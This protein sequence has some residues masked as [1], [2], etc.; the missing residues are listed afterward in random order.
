MSALEW[1]KETI[2]EEAREEGLQEGREEGRVQGLE[3]GRVQGLEEGREEGCHDALDIICL[4]NCELSP[5]DIAKKL[6]LNLEYVNIIIERYMH[7]LN[8]PQV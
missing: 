3:E 7:K 5:E 6:N 4:L 8:N 2:R 1:L